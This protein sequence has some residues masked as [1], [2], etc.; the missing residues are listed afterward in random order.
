MADGT[1]MA[2]GSLECR[3][4]MVGF[5]AASEEES[6]DDES[7]RLDGNHL[8]IS[9]L[10]R[11]TGSRNERGW[12]V[13][14]DGERGAGTGKE[15][16]GKKSEEV[17]RGDAPTQH[18]QCSTFLNKLGSSAEGPVRQ[19]HASLDPGDPDRR[20]ITTTSRVP[21]ALGACRRGEI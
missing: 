14:G 7:K 9:R 21:S 16:K 5:D 8:G 6:D 1:A 3:L 2:A 19:M 10:E 17:R 4:A 15:N 12:K 13:D 18:F 11:A 20:R